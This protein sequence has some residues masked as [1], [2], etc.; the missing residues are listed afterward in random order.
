MGYVIFS[1]PNKLLRVQLE[2]DA[3][4]STYAPAP[5][6]T[7]PL[8]RGKKVLRDRHK[9]DSLSPLPYLQAIDFNRLAGS[10]VC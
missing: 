1:K 5:E 7:K 3:N 6:F 9:K 8:M 4:V 2:V 10:F